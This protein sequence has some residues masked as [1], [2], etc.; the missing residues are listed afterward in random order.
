MGSQPFRTA[1]DASAGHD[2]KLVNWQ[3]PGWLCWFCQGVRAFNASF[4]GE[5]GDDEGVGW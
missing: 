4:D 2:A 3:N 5:S 1:A